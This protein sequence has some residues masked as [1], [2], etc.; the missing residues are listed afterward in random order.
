MKIRLF[1]LSMPPS[2]CSDRLLRGR[3]ITAQ[4]IRTTVRS[5]Y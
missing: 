3:G 4:K 5:V 1:F 2:L